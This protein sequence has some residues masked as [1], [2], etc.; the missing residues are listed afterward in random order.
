LG[1]SGRHKKGEKMN[2]VQSL[3]ARRK[4]K[5]I[6]CFPFNPERLDK[7]SNIF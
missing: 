3:S 6:F 2:E 1:G 4:K 7:F 5:R